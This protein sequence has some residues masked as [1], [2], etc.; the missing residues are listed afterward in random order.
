VNPTGNLFSSE[1]RIIFW[2]FICRN[3]FCPFFDAY[4]FAVTLLI[5]GR[6]EGLIKGD[7]FFFDCQLRWVF[8]LKKIVI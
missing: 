6:F 7:F 5:R 1:K 4:R 2:K 3:E 8:D